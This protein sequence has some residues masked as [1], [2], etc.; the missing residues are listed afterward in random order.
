MDPTL[1]RW[2]IPAMDLLATTL[3]VADTSA[4]AWTGNGAS[5]ANTPSVRRWRRTGASSP[6]IAVPGK[7]SYAMAAVRASGTMIPTAL[8][9]HGAC[10]SRAGTVPTTVVRPTE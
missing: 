9:V 8:T 1:V 7:E 10:V 5:V 2:A 4:S 6:S 3:P